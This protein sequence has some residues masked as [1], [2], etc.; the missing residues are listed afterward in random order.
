[1]IDNSFD[2]R[3][4]DKPKDEFDQDPFNDEFFT[5]M[6]SSEQLKNE[7]HVIDRE[8]ADMREGFAAGALNIVHTD[9]L[10]VA[11]LNISELLSQSANSGSA[12]A[13]GSSAASP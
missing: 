4:P 6:P 10:G 5:N 2:P 11:A 13:V 1:V 7:M 8:M 9:E 12:A 3:A